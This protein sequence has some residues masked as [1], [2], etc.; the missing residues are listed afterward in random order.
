MSEN[1]N[2]S[3]SAEQQSEIET[4]RKKYLPQTE[5]E[6]KMKK[7]RALDA[8]VGTSALIISMA[9]G[10]LSAL[11]FGAGMCC[12][13]LWSR[14]VLGSLVCLIGIVGMLLAPWVHRKIYEHRKQMLAPQILQLTEELNQR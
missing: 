1:F 4:I 8:S 7:L 13:L 2:Y 3:Y 14:Y 9:L 6:D 12:F 11:I 10:I 5:Q